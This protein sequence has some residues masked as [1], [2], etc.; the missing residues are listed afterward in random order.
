MV[1]RNVIVWFVILALCGC[2][3]TPDRFDAPSVDPPSAAVQAMELY[4]S[5]EDGALDNDELKKCPGLL[6]KKERYNADGNGS[7]SQSEIEE[8]I[9]K[10]FGRGT[11]GTQLRC[12]VLY[13]GSP[14]AGAK[15]VME[16]EPYIGE[17]VQTATGTTDGAGTTQL[18]IPAEF[19]PSHLHRVKAVHYGT[20]KVRITHPQIAIPPKYNSETELG[21]ETEVN[22]PL[23]RFDLK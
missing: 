18:A 11:G 22:N 6:L 5:N 4:D 15:V 1:T 16:P 12:T 8:G 17:A 10:L 14:L 23:V 19:L 3:R 7:L 21:Y 9:N 20:F 13:K 2:S